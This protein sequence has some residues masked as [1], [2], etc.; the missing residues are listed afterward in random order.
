MLIILLN[1]RDGEAEKEVDKDE[2][3]GSDDE[4]FESAEEEIP[5]VFASK[6][7]KPAEVAPNMSKKKK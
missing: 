3:D 5:V 7:R 1:F 4:D 6:K 2:E